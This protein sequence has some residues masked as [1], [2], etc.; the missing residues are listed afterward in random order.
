MSE[1]ISN[2][3]WEENKIDLPKVNSLLRKVH[4]YSWD[5]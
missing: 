4:K 2:D 3:I 5:W 1:F